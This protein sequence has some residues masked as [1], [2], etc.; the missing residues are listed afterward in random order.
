MICRRCRQIEISALFREIWALCVRNVRNLKGKYVICTVFRR[1][2]GGSRDFLGVSS[3]MIG[4]VFGD[5]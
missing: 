3:G 1:F 5:S 2:A 4:S